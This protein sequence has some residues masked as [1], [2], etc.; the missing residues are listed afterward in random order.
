MRRARGFTL[1]ELVAVMVVI[2]AV[3]VLVLPRLAG[4]RARDRVMAQARTVVSLAKSARARAA[5]EGRAYLLVIDPAAGQVRLARRRDPLAEAADPE[6]P[7]RERLDSAQSW[8]RPVPFERGVMVAEAQV[9]GVTL[10]LVDPFAITFRPTG[11]ADAALVVFE[12]AEGDR[13]GVS[14]EPV[15]GRAT[16]VEELGS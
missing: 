3:G 9:Q 4:G 7:E 5:G 16:I 13:V 2:S 14:V 1:L 15:L 6:D 11:E 10:L 12:S 8:S